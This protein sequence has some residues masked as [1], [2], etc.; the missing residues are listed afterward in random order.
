[1][2][3]PFLAFRGGEAVVRVIN[4]VAFAT[5]VGFTLIIFTPLIKSLIVAAMFFAA[6]LIWF[7]QVFYVHD[8]LQNVEKATEK[9]KRFPY[10]K[11]YEKYGKDKSNDS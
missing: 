10:S 9:S 7:V 11:M 8:L 4:M 2:D 6:I 5:I 3:T 1:M